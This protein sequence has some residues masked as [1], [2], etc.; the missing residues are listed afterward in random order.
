M[1]R[2][3]S[4]KPSAEELERIRALQTKAAVKQ[5]AI[6]LCTGHLWGEVYFSQINY[7]KGSSAVCVRCGERRSLEEIQ[8][9][10]ASQWA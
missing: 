3:D 5:A 8:K 7:S 9:D 10:P 6:D 2:C 1:S 4:M